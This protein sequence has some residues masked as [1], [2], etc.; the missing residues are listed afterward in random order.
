MGLLATVVLAYIG[1]PIIAGGV[2]V[3]DIGSLIGIFV[4]GTESR[5]DERLTK[6]RIMTGQDVASPPS[7]NKRLPTSSDELP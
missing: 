7:N 6:T 1:Q 5:K 3:L 2:A 4:Y